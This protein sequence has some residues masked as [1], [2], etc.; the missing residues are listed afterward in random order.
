MENMNINFNFEQPDM[1]AG[2]R[3]LGKAALVFA[4]VVSFMF[5]LPFLFIFSFGEMIEGVRRVPGL[6]VG[7]IFTLLG[8][9]LLIWL[10][11]IVKKERITNSYIAFTA[12]KKVVKFTTLAEFRDVS[13]DIVIK[14]LY[15]AIKKGYFSDAYMDLENQC[16]L[17]PNRDLGGRETV[18]CSKCGA[19]F[20]ALTGYVATCPY[21]NET[22]NM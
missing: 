19:S 15:S 5:G 12:N 1:R 11:L 2:V 22:V 20:T 18:S 9:G 13:V 7:M 21:C 4:I 16:I 10:I 8:V 3:L 14:E 6:S 17:F